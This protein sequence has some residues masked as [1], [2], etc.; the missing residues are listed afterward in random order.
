[1]D[2]KAKHLVETYYEKFS[3]RNFDEK[4]LYCFLTFVK[5]DVQDIKVLKD[6]GDFIVQREHYTGF[7]KEYF[8]E[9]IQII[10]DM[11][12]GRSLKKIEDLFSFRE[13]R[14]GFNALFLKYG[15]E[16]LSPEVIN[17][18]ILC[19]ISLLQ[20]IPLRS[21]DTGREVGYLSFAASSKE[22]FLMGN[23][24]TLN[25][26]RYIPVTFQV[27]RT[28]NSYEKITPQDKNDTPYLFDK[29]I[30]EVINVDR[31]LVITFPHLVQA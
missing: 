10:K 24:K 7:V 22:V 14:N 28:Q 12:K 21:A 29:E 23:T 25:K 31:Q 17:D 20:S 6:L 8:D 19:I 2:K 9:S 27:L 13:I 4:D 26:G 3:I 5:N 1:M 16:K 18:F 11:E 15:Y 30:I